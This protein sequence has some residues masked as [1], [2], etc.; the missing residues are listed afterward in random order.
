MGG[1]QDVDQ[2]FRWMIRR[3][4]IKPGTGGRFVVLRASGADGYNPYNFLTLR[5]C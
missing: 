1:G 3:A 4:G 2:A 5:V